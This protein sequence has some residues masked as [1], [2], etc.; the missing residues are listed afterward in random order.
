MSFGFYLV[1]QK[2]IA[3][4]QKLCVDDDSLAL[5]IRSTAK[6]SVVD[7]KRGRS[8][9]SPTIILRDSE[10]PYDALK[11]IITYSRFNELIIKLN[12]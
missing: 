6:S 10:Y 7:K 9:S 1:V 12:F 5:E 4:Q 2:A 11:G 8:L 3:K